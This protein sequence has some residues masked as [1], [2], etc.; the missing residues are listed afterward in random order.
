MGE[1]YSSLLKDIQI[2][3]SLGKGRDI[4]GN[5]SE[6]VTFSP[7]ERLNIALWLKS[8]LAILSTTVSMGEERAE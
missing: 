5:D 8:Y 2:S 4:K 1:C 7:I 3:F 6:G